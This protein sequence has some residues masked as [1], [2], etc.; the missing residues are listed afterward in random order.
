MANKLIT[1][2]SKNDINFFQV[3]RMSRPG[4]NQHNQLLEY[5][6]DQ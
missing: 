3:A 5:F 2:L 1:N 4:H 6:L